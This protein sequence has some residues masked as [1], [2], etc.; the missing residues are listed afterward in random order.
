M[1][2]AVTGHHPQEAFRPRIGSTPNLHRL[3]QAALKHIP[4]AQPIIEKIFNPKPVQKEVMPVP[5]R[6]LLMHTGFF[7]V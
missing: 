6:D 4:E 5:Q 7:T 1:Y 2:H 3:A